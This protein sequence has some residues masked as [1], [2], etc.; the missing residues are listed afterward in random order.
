[1][2]IKSQPLRL[3]FRCADVN[4]LLMMKMGEMATDEKIPTRIL[5]DSA[6]RN[7]KEDIIKQE[8]D[9]EDQHGVI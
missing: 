5:A 7:C 2:K 9:I 1:L 3:T 8:F 4:M 6:K